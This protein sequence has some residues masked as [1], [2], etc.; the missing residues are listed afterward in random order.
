M[1]MSLSVL[2]NTYLLFLFKITSIDNVSLLHLQ[3]LL[4]NFDVFNFIFK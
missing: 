3:A 1:N 4:L 2:T